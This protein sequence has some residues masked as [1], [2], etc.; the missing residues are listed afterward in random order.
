MRN[1]GDVKKE[2]KKFLTSLGVWWYMPVPTGFGVQGVPDF[3]GVYKGQSFFI[4]TK[5]GK[6]KLTE[7]QEKQIAAIRRAG[8]KVWVVN[9]KNL[10]DFKSV[11]VPV[12]E[13]KMTFV[14]DDSEPFALVR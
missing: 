5:F 8:A 13:Q 12:M 4:E 6:G 11:F 7:W 9:E 14:T 1:E 10:A 3:I 2:V